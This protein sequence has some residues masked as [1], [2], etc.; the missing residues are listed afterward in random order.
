MVLTFNIFLL[1]IES[2]YYDF[3][4]DGIFNEYMN[5]FFVKTNQ[6]GT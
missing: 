4:V 1:L 2:Y 3:V 5:P 6:R